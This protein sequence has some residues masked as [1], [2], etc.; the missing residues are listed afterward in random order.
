M[1]E[2]QINVKVVRGYIHRRISGISYAGRGREG[3]RKSGRG[4]G[5]RGL[6][7]KGAK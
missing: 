6:R 4:E 3:R 2:T 5:R 1:L 7:L